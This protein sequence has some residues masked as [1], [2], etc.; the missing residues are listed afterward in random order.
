MKHNNSGLHRVEKLIKWGIEEL[1]RCHIKSPR[2]DA[3]VLLSH[4]MNKSRLQLYLDMKEVVDKHTESC[5]INLIR[6]RK[7]NKPV[8]YITGHKEF[9]SLD[10]IVDGHVL[11]PRPETEL[12]VET[13]CEIGKS[14]GLILDLG[15]G[16]GAIAVSLAKYNPG[17][18][19]VATD[20]SINALL[21]ARKNAYKHK[22]EDRIYFVQSDL[23]DAFSSY[24]KFSWVVSN[25]PY[26][27]TGDLD[28]LTDDIRRYE[29]MLAL[30]GGADGLDV[31][32]CILSEAHKIM[33]P[34]GYLAIEMGYDQSESVEE[35]ARRMGKYSDFHIV[36][37]Y[38]DLPR[39]FYCRYCK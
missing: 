38:S 11:I 23:F 6:D 35:I 36:K 7:E 13:V 37:D 20:L 9:M 26:V 25:P 39:I 14:Q 22:V 12:L 5:Y 10:F 30:D 18:R 29:P 33:N 19:I 34:G 8:S 21:V 2:L 32:R 27:P 17:W 28:Y 31:I 1:E 15:T 16:S 3:E 4:A 24:V